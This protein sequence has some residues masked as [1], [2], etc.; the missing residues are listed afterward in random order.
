MKV[1]TICIWSL[2]LLMIR[3]PPRSTRTD[4]L[5]PY[6]TLFRSE[7]KRAARPAH[8]HRRYADVAGGRARRAGDR[9][10]PDLADLAGC[11]G[12]ASGARAAGVAA[13]GRQPTRRLSVAS[14]AAAVGSGAPRFLR[15]RMRAS[16]RHRKTVVQGKRVSGGVI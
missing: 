9:A 2:F 12:R 11:P 5:V 3:R 10:T 4:P 14:G 15:P 8:H 6:T 7:G 13:A 16:T 1:A